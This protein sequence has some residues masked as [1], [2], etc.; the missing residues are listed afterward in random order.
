MNNSDMKNR[1]MMKS[2]LSAI[3]LTT[4]LVTT[5]APLAHAEQTSQKKNVLEQ[6]EEIP[7]EEKVGLS[8]G[9][10]IGGIF[11][12]PPGAF[13]TAL[14]G[15]FI[16]KHMVAEKEIIAL[17]NTVDKQQLTAS[18]NE[19]R[20][21][22]EIKNL[23]IQYQQEM[24]NI[25]SAYEHSEKAQ[26]ENILVSLMFRTGSSDIE[27]HYQQQVI[28]LAKVLQRSPHLNIDLSG[29]TDKQG[30]EQLNLALAEQRV[31]K[32]KELLAAQ[33]INEQR[34]IT[35]AFGELAP[36]DQNVASE[37]NYFDRRVEMKLIVNSEE[38][39]KQAKL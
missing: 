7:T 14:A 28:A 26:V 30:E 21:Q 36:I 1:T 24:M 33:G 31:S 20:H 19:N 11:G 29:Y 37:V 9:A 25:A 5:M 23:E 8:L 15:D 16:G 13:I 18:N 34:I 6:I 10:I 2:K 4:A 3:V 35:S 32:V 12:G 39:A 38:V 22:G 27:P 17:E